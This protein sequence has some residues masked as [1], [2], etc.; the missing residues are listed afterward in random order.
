MYLNPAIQNPKAVT[1]T[2]ADLRKLAKKEIKQ[3]LLNLGF[4]E[5]LI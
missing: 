1:G 5:D 2:D 4:K 3:K